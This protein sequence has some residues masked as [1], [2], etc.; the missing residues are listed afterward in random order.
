MRRTLGTSS[1]RLPPP[2]RLEEVSNVKQSFGH[3]VSLSVEPIVY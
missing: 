2:L 1:F 3:W